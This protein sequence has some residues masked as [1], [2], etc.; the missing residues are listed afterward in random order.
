MNIEFEA[1]FLQIDKD[2]IRA[3]LREAGAFLVHP[4][5]LMKRSVFDPPRHIDGG[6]LRVRQEYDQIT[7]SLKVVDGKKITD[8]KEVQIVID[9]FEEG[10]TF[11]TSI[12][13]TK[14]A[15]QETRRELW[16]LDEVDIT[17]DTWPGLHPFVEV[18]GE[19]EDVVKMVS[20]KIG[21]DYAQAEFC[22]V[23]FIY[24]KELGIPPQIMKDET[25]MITFDHVPQK[26][27]K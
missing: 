20:E 13:A 11:L 18:E 10:E 7:M 21:F 24:Q 14:K 15:Y 8:Q 2:D 16:K 19:N 9:D 12:G 6:W 5:Y 4:E 17:I 26:Y 22:E 3:R 23:S 27:E 25:P 1:T